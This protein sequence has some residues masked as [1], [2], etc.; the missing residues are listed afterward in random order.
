MSGSWGWM[1]RLHT[2]PP[3]MGSEPQ[4]GVVE[5]SP[6]KTGA[7][8]RKAPSS[9]AG[10]IRSIDRR[11][12]IP[13]SNDLRQNRNGDLARA[14]AAD[15]QTDGSLQL[16]LGE[17]EALRRQLFAHPGDLAPAPHESQV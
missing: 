12:L 11:L 15:G 1:A 3:Q 10:R 5:A 17:V 14:V 2:S 6:A 16:D 13:L 4:A 7:T 9:R 8:R